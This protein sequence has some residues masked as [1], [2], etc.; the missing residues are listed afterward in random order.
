MSLA[1]R[2]SAEVPIGEDQWSHKGPDIKEEAHPAGAD[3]DPHSG[4]LAGHTLELGIRAVPASQRHH[5]VQGS[6]AEHQVEK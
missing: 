3:L 1:L 5:D 2:D 6:Q 4:P